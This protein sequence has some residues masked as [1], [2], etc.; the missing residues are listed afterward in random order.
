MSTPPDTYCWGVPS[1]RG[2]ALGLGLARLGALAG[3]L[4]ASALSLAALITRGAST[5]AEA[6]GAGEGLRRRQWI[7]RAGTAATAPEP[8]GPAGYR[9]LVEDCAAVAVSHQVLVA[10]TTATSAGDLSIGLGSWR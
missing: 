4:A 6:A 9:R 7:E 1:S 3:G 8:A 5:M 10:A 2:V